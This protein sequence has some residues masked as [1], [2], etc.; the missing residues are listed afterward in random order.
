[1]QDAFTGQPTRIR[2]P[3]PPGA[4]GRAALQ[5]DHRRRLEALARLG[6][7]AAECGLRQDSDRDLVLL[8][9]DEVILPEGAG[10]E[11][12]PGAPALP[13]APDEDL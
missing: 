11:C 6:E 5:D 13:A 7:A 2:G 8:K 3:L 10:P 9:E 4:E 12:D 1:M